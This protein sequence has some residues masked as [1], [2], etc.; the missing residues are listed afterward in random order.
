[1]KSQDYLINLSQSSWDTTIVRYKIFMK[2]EIVAWWLEIT[3]KTSRDFKHARH[4]TWW[5]L[6]VCVFFTPQC[7]YYTVQLFNFVPVSHW[8]S[9]KIHNHAKPNHLILRFRLFKLKN[10]QYS[11]WRSIKFTNYKFQLPHICRQIFCISVLSHAPLWISSYFWWRT[12]Y[13][14]VVGSAG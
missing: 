9:K 1:M 10:I 2:Q 12:V 7:I 6:M 8:L 5:S 11:S 13:L 4:N 3:A 14:L